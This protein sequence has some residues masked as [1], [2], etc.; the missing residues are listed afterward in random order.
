VSFPVGQIFVAGC[1]RHPYVGGEFLSHAG[2]AL[3]LGLHPL[4]RY[5]CI[6]LGC[7]VDIFEGLGKQL[8]V[9][10]DGYDLPVGLIVGFAT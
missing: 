9:P 4:M 10:L 6:G 5:H 1:D 8:V 3:Q 7:L 2:V